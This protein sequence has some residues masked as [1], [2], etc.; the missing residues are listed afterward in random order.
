LLLPGIGRYTAGAVLSIAYGQDVPAPDGNARRILVR[1]FGID[2]DVTHGTGQRRLWHLAE[3]LLPPG[4]AGEFN[5]AL[6]DLG[7][8]VCT[9]RAPSCHKCP[10]EQC[11]LAHHLGREEAFPVRRQRRSLPHYEVAAGVVWNSDGHFLIAKRPPEGLLGGLWEF[12]GGKREPGENLEDCLR[13]ELHEE[14]DIQVTV[15]ASFAVVKHTYTHF[16]IT[17]HAFHCELDHGQPRAVGCADWKWI[18]LDQVERF[19]FSAADHK[20]IAALRAAST[21]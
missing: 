18:T 5:Q 1:V 19:A 7:A 6:M 11:C 2:K 17:M 16:R 12:P 9:P 14:L 21:L 15:G 10:F 20:I 13:R 8:S 3:S 4:R